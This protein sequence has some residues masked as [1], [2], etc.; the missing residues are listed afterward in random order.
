AHGAAVSHLCRKCARGRF[1]LGFPAD[2]SCS[3]DRRD[4]RDL[5]LACSSPSGR[6]APETTAAMG[7]IQEEAMNQIKST[8]SSPPMYREEAPSAAHTTDETNKVTYAAPDPTHA[9]L[10]LPS[11][12]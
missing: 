5:R 12:F 10:P 8:N 7:P 9:L 1:Y 3:G 6:V 4:H 11:L 2:A